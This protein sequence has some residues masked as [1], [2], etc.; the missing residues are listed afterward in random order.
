[1][2][3][4]LKVMSSPVEIS[5]T[6]G[7]PAR[8]AAPTA[9]VVVVPAHNEES[10]LSRCL[11]SLRRAAGDVTVPVHVVVA[12]DSCVDDSA[13]L[14]P[15]TMSRVWTD[16]RN[17]GAARAAG[18][19]FAASAFGHGGL[20]RLWYATTD[21]D[22]AVPS[23]WLTAQL[24]HTDEADVTV[25]TVAVRW[26]ERDEHVR[27]E[28]ERRYRRR[29]AGG[30]GHVHG[31]NLGF[32]ADWYHRVGGF[33]PMSDGEDVD[34]VARL[35]AA[36]ARIARPEQP[37]VLTSDRLGNRVRD[38]FAGYLSGLTSAPPDCA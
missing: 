2:P 30:H 1:M 22:S 7:E 12:L 8:R 32:R 26:R 17:V 27:A 4:G 37:A 20:E 13:R 5:D 21:A 24:S 36:G 19:A 35:A 31:A 3:E 28:Y 9:V 34:L 33:R 38:G 16:A 15:P 23:D 14:V 10:L 25:G 11:R 6:D 29:A 18:F